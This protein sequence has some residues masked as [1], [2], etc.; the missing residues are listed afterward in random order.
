MRFFSPINRLSDAQLTYLTEVDG[1][2]HVVLVALVNDGHQSTG[3]GIGRYIRN[4]QDPGVAEFAITVS[5]QYQGRGVGSLLLDSM[6]VHACENNVL[7]LRGYV[8]SENRPMIQMLKRR[9]AQCVEEE[10][11]TFRC[12]L[13]TGKR[14]DTY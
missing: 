11:R 9:G 13:E 4:K 1:V 2:N 12:D 6:I 10:M 8:L 7:I 5:D 14:D 3:I